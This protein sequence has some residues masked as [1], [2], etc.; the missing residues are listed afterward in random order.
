V[1]RDDAKALPLPRPAPVIL[2]TGSCGDVSRG[3]QH[4][5]TVV[6]LAASRQMRKSTR[7]WQRPLNGFLK[8]N[9][10][11]AGGRA[12]FGSPSFTRGDSR[13]VIPPGRHAAEPH[14]LKWLWPPG[15]FPRSVE[16][17]HCKRVG[18]TPSGKVRKDMKRKNLS[19][20]TFREGV[21][22]VS[23]DNRSDAEGRGA[24]EFEQGRRCR[25]GE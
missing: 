3:G 1:T 20:R 18:D 17:V 21:N 13:R 4:S 25:Q 23:P 6:I 22:R 11:I 8:R 15:A 2:D 9:G 10:R 5:A 12:S 7:G 14:V 24:L 19:L 16:L